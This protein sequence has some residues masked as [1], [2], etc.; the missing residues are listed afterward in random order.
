MLGCGIAGHS[1]ETLTI[2]V[3]QDMILEC[4]EYQAE[5]SVTTDWTLDY[6]QQGFA[7]SQQIL[8]SGAAEGYSVSTELEIR[9][10]Y[11]GNDH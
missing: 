9:P 10:F 7:S 4:A 6:C 8:D 5:T 1:K 11:S 3:N 2:P